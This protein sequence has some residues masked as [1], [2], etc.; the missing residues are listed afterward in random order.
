[1]AMGVSGGDGMGERPRVQGAACCPAAPAFGE[2]RWG[3]IAML[4]RQIAL[5]TYFVSS[6][7]IADKLLRGA[8]VQ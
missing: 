3:R 8:L 5:G 1:M 6:G 7:E 2:V 4:Q